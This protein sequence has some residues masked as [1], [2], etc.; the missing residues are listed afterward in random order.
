M[1]ESSRNLKV[2]A[3]DLRAN[4]TESESR[5]WSRLRRKQICGVQFYRQRPIAEYIVDFYAHSVRLVI[6]LDG[7]QHFE[8]E[9]NLK[10]RLRDRNLKQLGLEV[11]RFDNRQV[12]QELDGVVQK[13]TFVVERQ[14]IKS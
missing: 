13:I 14:L 6:E 1:P 12:L 7:G 9:H 2:L 5:L 8:E 4:M 11:L 10:D 3:R